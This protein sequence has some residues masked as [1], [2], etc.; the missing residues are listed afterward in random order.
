[1]GVSCCLDT[2]VDLTCIIEEYIVI[3]YVNFEEI[4]QKRIMVTDIKNLTSIPIC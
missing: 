2:K 1:M 3:K 4:M